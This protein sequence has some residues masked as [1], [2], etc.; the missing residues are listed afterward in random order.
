M[1]LWNSRLRKVE[2][3]KRHEIKCKMLS[4]KKQRLHDKILWKWGKQYIVLYEM[5]L[6]EG[7]GIFAM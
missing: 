6:W 3:R 4:I 7:G 1:I 5:I 2:K